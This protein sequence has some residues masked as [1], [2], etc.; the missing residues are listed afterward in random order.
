VAAC[1]VVSELYYDR[2]AQHQFTSLVRE[3]ARPGELM[4][5]TGYDFEFVQVEKPYESYTGNN[6]KLRYASCCLYYT[7]D[8]EYNIQINF[9]FVSEP[10]NR[11]CLASSGCLLASKVFL[12]IDYAIYHCSE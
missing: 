5:N 8:V 10:L 6:V 2:G 3:L 9:N 12:V 7:D 11:R 4:E 1:F